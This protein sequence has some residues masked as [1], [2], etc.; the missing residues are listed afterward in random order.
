MTTNGKLH[1]VTFGSQRIAFTLEFRDRERL[2][3]NVHPDRTVTVVAPNGRSVQE[4]VDRVQKRAGWI[5]KQRA[6]FDQFHPLTPPRRFVAGETHFYLGRQYRLKLVE[7]A[8]TS[9]KLKGRFLWVHLP[10][11]A[12]AAR[13]EL[14]L[15]QWYRDHAEP[16]FAR[17]L[18]ECLRSARSLNV[19]RPELTIRKMVKRWGSCTKG[20]RI[21]LNTELVK[22]PPYCIEYVIMHELCHLRL[23]DHSPEFYRLLARCMPDW[24]QRKRRL[25]CFIL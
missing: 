18:D 7:D 21:L 4:V 23:H 12:D 25:E 16:I 15:D 17:R 19:E 2:A 6:Y 14:L 11:R 9:V 10:D 5:V 1:E 8:K 22:T 3:I 24:E 20:G 13:I